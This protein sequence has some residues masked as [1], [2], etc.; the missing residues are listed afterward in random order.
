LGFEKSAILFGINMKKAILM[1]RMLEMRLF[2]LK[3][4]AAFYS[5]AHSECN[6]KRNLKFLGVVS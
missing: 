3:W 4:F 1:P 2:W 6:S 5:P